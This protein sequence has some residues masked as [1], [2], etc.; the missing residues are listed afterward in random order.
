MRAMSKPRRRLI[1]VSLGPRTTVEAQAALAE[2]A[3]QA[4]VAELRLDLMAECDLPRLLRNRPC[5]V[6]VTN[7]PERAGGRFRGGE[8]ERVRPLLEA[9]DLGAEYVDVEHDA[10]HLIPDRKQTGLVVS[11]HDFER[12]PGDLLQIHQDLAARGADVVKVVGTA[13]RIQDN[14]PVLDVL[15]RS[16]HPTIA[17]AMGEAGLISR[18]LALRYDACLLT[19]A[20]LGQR[21]RVAPGQLP[22]ATMREVYQADKIGAQTA[23][24]GVLSAE[25][26][27][28][29][30]LAS[31]NAATRGAGLDGVWVPF[32]A[33]GQCG[34]GPAEV[35]RA[36]RG[37]GVAG[38]VVAESAQRAALPALDDVA[39]AGPGDRISAVYVANGRLVGTWAPTLS[40]ALALIT[41]HEVALAT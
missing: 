26:V 18:V 21:E 5:P 41:G 2:V 14:L 4:D 9:I 22:V 3:R 25:G 33:P 24:Y 29:A 30:L 16:P 15:A 8:A 7:R 35:L 1:A 28:D 20:A 34:D 23:I 38:Y 6:A 10:T 17:I 11:Y 39:L 32:V 12:M 40:D 37:L 13:R 27:P 19:Y 31:L 36:Y